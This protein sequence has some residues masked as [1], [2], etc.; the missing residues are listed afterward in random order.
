MSLNLAVLGLPGAGKG[1]QSQKISD[2]YDVPAVSM[3]DLLRAE[4]DAVIRYDDDEE[5][6]RDLY[7]IGDAVARTQ[8][9]ELLPD[10]LE[11]IGQRLNN[12]E[13]PST[14]TSTYFLEQRLDQS[15]CEQGYVIDGF[16]RWQEQAD[17]MD[18]IDTLD[19]IIYLDV[20]EDEIYRRLMERGRDDDTPDAIARR[21]EWQRDGLDDV[22]DHYSDSTVPVETIDADP[23]PDDVWADIYDTMEQYTGDTQ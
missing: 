14:A 11:T 16:P 7:R 19:A 5:E 8:E 3:G 2:R 12:G 4:S 10:Y 23:S 15:D 20:S 17:A 6:N 13:G 1:T 18:D 21:I 9:P 22:L